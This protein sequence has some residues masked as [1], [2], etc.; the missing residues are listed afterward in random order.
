MLRQVA[1]SL[2][3]VNGKLRKCEE[4]NTYTDSVF[5]YTDMLEYTDLFEYTD[6]I[7]EDTDR[8]IYCGR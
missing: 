5:E 1:A 2:S 6:S 3:E 4:I 8:Q 7:F